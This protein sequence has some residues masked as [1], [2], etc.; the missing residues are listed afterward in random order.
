MWKDWPDGVRKKGETYCTKWNC[1]EQAAYETNTARDGDNDGW[2][3]E[4]QTG[5]NHRSHLAFGFGAAAQYTLRGPT[6]TSATIDEQRIVRATADRD[7]PVRPVA[8]ASY[9]WPCK[10]VR[11]GVM[12]VLD[13]NI[14]GQGSLV[15]A[16]GVGFGFQIGFIST[17]SQA[18]DQSFGI[19]IVYMRDSAVKK[20]PGRFHC[21][22]T[23]SGGCNGSRVHGHER[24]QATN[25]AHLLV[26]MEANR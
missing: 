11:C 19:G 18:R 2:A 20:A 24:R 15:N 16:S 3:C 10:K 8:T 13:T 4:P 21:G 25:G 7:E 12:G 5:E 1:A 23:G 26:R 17:E 6:V 14:F 9:L 22:G